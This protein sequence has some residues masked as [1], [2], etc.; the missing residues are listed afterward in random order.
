MAEEAIVKRI[1]SRRDAVC[2]KLGIEFGYAADGACLARLDAGPDACN[3]YGVVHGAVLF[4]MADTGMGFA[5]LEALG[6]QPLL[7]SIT[8]T[9]TYL[10]PAAPGRI[11]ARAAVARLG[12]S[13]AFLTCAVRDGRGDECA[14]FSGV[15]RVRSEREGSS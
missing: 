9:A 8:V 13:V 6:G 15:F 4:A 5:L 10:R 12:R 2:D 1:E 7:S 11:E 3:V 14:Q